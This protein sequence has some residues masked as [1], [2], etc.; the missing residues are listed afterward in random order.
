MD[1]RD[2]ARALALGRVAIGAGL[3]VAP[4]RIALLVGPAAAEPAGRWLTRVG[5][6]RDLLLGVL[7][8]QALDAK[9]PVRSLLVAGAVAD[10]V[11]FAATVAAYRRLPRFGRVVL[12]GAA[13]GAVALGLR[14]A[15]RLD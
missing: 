5:G 14:L 9:A 11:D 7:T 2:L 8:L 12:L 10:G 15:S 4:G 13:G 3:L 1:D 6:I